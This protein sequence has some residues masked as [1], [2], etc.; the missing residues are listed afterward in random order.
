MENINLKFLA[1][2]IIGLPFV[3][4]Y[5]HRSINDL[6]YPPENVEK[7]ANLYSCVSGLGLLFLYVVMWIFF[8][9][10]FIRQ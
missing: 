4:Y 8:V 1:A 3:I 7:R 6:K 9:I 5:S 10:D 2:L